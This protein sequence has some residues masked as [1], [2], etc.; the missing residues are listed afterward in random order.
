MSG[1]LKC[2]SLPALKIVKAFAEQERISLK[3]FLYSHSSPEIAR[4][5]ASLNQYPD[6]YLKQVDSFHLNMEGVESH[7]PVLFRFKNGSSF[8]NPLFGFKPLTEYRAYY[9]RVK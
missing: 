1:P 4:K 5:I 6:E 9:R 3:V 8:G 7:R 2:L